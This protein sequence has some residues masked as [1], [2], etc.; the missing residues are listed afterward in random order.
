MSEPVFSWGDP[1]GLEDE[2]AEDEK[3]VRDTAR[4]YAQEVFMPRVLAAYRDES[5]NP[6]MFREMG[7][8]GL[9]GPTTPE[10]Y[11]GA[12]LGYV[13]YGLIAREIERV[14]SGCRS[15]MS[16]QS[17]LVMYPILAYGTEKQRRKYLPDLATAKLIGCFGLSEPDHG[18]DPCASTMASNRARAAPDVRS[19]S[20]GD[21]EA[22]VAMSK[23]DS[24]IKCRNK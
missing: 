7:N 14:Q 9:L 5:A 11:G 2:L 10:S 13:A 15:A 8:I 24:G 21:F 22:A 4:G 23:S 20:A 3:M 6:E 12:G 18:S 19:C 17:S 1:L 16:V